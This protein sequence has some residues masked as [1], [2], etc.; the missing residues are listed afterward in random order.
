[1]AHYLLRFED[2]TFVLD[3][4][5]DE[6]CRIVDADSAHQAVELTGVEEGAIQVWTLRSDKPRVFE[7]KTEFGATV[8]RVE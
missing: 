2:D 1:M 8:R 3:S 4:G 5:P 7:V 6:Q